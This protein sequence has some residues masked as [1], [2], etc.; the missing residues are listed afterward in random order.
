MKKI[1]LINRQPPYGTNCMREALDVLLMASTFAQD[2]SV[3]FL[4]DGVW[5]LRTQQDTQL[6][7]AK[8]F[9]VIYR[10]LPLYEIEKVY[11]ELEALEKYGL[12]IADLAIKAEVL[13]SAQV[14]ELLP[15]QDCI[16]SF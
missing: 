15:Q 11:V 14:A 1:L 7:G 6:I 8:N 3:L 12:T 9:S 16:L 2:L 4:G 10:A 13:T 5:Q